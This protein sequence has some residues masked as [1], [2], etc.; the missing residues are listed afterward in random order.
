MPPP[1]IVLAARRPL[2]GGLLA[3]AALTAAVAAA[4]PAPPRGA[5]LPPAANAPT[6]HR[7]RMIGDS[8]GYRFEPAQL[9]VA[10]GDRVSFV[11][12]SGGPHNVAF[13]EASVPAAARAR[14]AA[15][16]PDATDLTGPLLMTEGQTY[17]IAFAGVPAGTYPYVCTPHAAMHMT[18]TIVV[19]GGAARRAPAGARGTAPHA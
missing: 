10:P 1:F 2:R 7:V 14:L 19:R 17:T 4:P 13:D 3:A 12:A 18:G 5:T 15:N 11:M 8:K 9:T 6:V 16:M